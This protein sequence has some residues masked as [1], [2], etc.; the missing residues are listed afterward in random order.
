MRLLARAIAPKVTAFA[1]HEGQVR[2]SEQGIFLGASA[3]V[4]QRAGFAPGRL[5]LAALGARVEMRF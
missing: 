1:Q 4:G 2:G 5:K 3:P